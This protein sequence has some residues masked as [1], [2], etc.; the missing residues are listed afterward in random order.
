MSD[1]NPRDETGNCASLK[2]Q[3]SLEDQ[4]DPILND[5]QKK[6][7]L[8]LKMGLGD[9]REAEKNGKREPSGEGS[10]VERLQVVGLHTRHFGRLIV[11]C[12]RLFQDT[13]RLLARAPI[14]TAGHS[15]GL[16]SHHQAC[17]GA[18]GE[19]TGGGKVPNND[20]YTIELL[21]ETESLELVVLDQV[22]TKG[23]LAATSFNLQLPG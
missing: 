23:L 22:L 16:R 13:L 8:L 7:A 11:T 6:A 9:S 14:S 18:S 15:R 20:E 1:D 17:M 5:L 10:R 12:W 3:R 21:D 19:V 2:D 4:M